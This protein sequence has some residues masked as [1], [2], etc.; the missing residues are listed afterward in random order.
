MHRHKAH[1]K[2]LCVKMKTSKQVY[3]CTFSTER[4]S[5]SCFFSCMWIYKFSFENPQFACD[6]AK[7]IQHIYTL[8]TKKKMKTKSCKKVKRKEKKKNAK[9][10]S[11]WE[12]MCAWIRSSKHFH[13][14]IVLL[15][16]FARE[17][18]QFS[19]E[20]NCTTANRTSQKRGKRKWY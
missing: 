5:N 16:S 8:R 19:S 11:K 20:L 6:Q 12:I 4:R 7:T 13:I 9:S 2:Y 14:H 1:T 18:F 10:K 17:R 15:S 3:V